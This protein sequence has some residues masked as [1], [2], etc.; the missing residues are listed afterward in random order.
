MRAKR[1]L[2]W[3]GIIAAVLAAHAAWHQVNLFGPAEAQS[4]QRLPSTPPGIKVFSDR[5][6][7]RF[8]TRQATVTLTPDG[9]LRVDAP[10]E[11]LVR[12][13]DD[14]KIEGYDITL[15]ASGDVAVEAGGNFSVA[16]N[17]LLLGGRNSD[18]FLADGSY[19][20]MVR[21]DW[22]REQPSERV[23]AR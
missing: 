18:V 15:D 7:I 1:V 19:P 12:C 4:V 8:V 17:R 3:T 22:E 16:A 23:K 14:V 10:K 5:D 9:T 6:A 2:L 20:L 13:V 11:V 21:D